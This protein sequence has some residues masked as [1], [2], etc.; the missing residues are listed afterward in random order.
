VSNFRTNTGPGSR[1][2]DSQANS[3]QGPLKEPGLL[4]VTLHARR[5]LKGGNYTDSKYS[6]LSWPVLCS[7]PYCRQL[8][9]KETQDDRYHWKLDWKAEPA[10]SGH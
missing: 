10:I 3:K 2:N 6:A 9:C 7:N 5:N 8:W 4:P 1:A